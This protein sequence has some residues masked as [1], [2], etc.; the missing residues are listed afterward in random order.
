MSAVA[1]RWLWVIGLAL[2]VLVL[3]GGL[4]FRQAR[5]IES[6]LRAARDLL[7]A[8]GDAV[9]D[10]RLAD[11]RAGLATA[12]G[13]LVRANG[14]LHTSTSLQA[15]GWLPGV[16]QNLATIRD[17][18]A[19]ALTVVSGAGRLLAVASPLESADGDLEVP[20]RRGAIP[21]DVVAAARLEANSLAIALPVV[22]DDPPGRFV[23]DRVVELH[24]EVLEEAILRRR[25]LVD[26]V[27]GLELLGELTG[28]NGSRRYLIAVANTAEMRGSGGMILSYGVLES[29][30]GELSLP[31]FGGID[32]LFL[33][34]GVDPAVLGVDPS[35]LRR[36]DG[37][38]ITRLWR[39][40]NVL[41]DFSV[42]APRM[43][44]MYQAATG[45]AVDGV[46]Q[47][48]AAGLAAVLAGVGPVEVAGI[49]RVDE[50]NAVELT[51]NRAYTLFP[52]RDQ[53]Q[54]V[55]GDVAEAVF[56]RLV[57]GEYESVRPLGAALLQAAAERHV[58]LWSPRPG[59][60]D[61]L[62]FFDADGALPD[63]D[64]MDSLFLTVQ[65]FARNKLDFYLDT[66]VRVAGERPVSGPGRLRVEVTVRNDAPAGVTEPAY[67]FGDGTGGPP[68]R[69]L[70]VASL[71]VPTGTALT[72]STGRGEVALVGEG[73][74]SALTWRVDLPAGTSS[75]VVLELSLPPRPTG[76]YTLTLA[77]LPRV[78]PTT[79]AVEVDDGEGGQVR[80]DGLLERREV[81]AAEPGGEGSGPSAS[82]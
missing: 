12:Q 66:S 60:V 39:N 55:L 75:T 57:E 28:E 17:S 62:R 76:A 79:Y 64:V 72:S 80:Y 27:N 4:A 10:G 24:E 8:A 65:N 56:D 11:A 7:V 34:A 30:G 36:W 37:L 13:L 81:L 59:A 51:L 26:L 54:E 50:D 6:D 3:A 44:A 40:V 1:R 32:E 73:R 78:R 43:A 71:Y 52:D 68:G 61:P 48:D 16:D 77:P 47:I 41:P 14:A 46:I 82:N 31:A 19:L 20:L 25:Q 49:G 18:V 69:Y 22:D 35:E 33:D 21:L 2:S 5:E 63:G 9:E 70:G 45:Q 38:E 58:V 67:V 23:V 42:V 15:V 53:R 74:R 29:A